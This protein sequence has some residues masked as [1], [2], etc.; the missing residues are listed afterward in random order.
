MNINELMFGAAAP[1]EKIKSINAMNESDLFSVP[2]STIKRIIEEVGEC[3]YQSTDK[4]LR[5]PRKRRAG[6]HWDSVLESIFLWKGN[7]YFD[8]YIQ[9]GDCDTDTNQS[10]SFAEVMKRGDY[11]G[12]IK[13]CDRYGSPKNYY[14]IYD[15]S[16]KADC[17]KSILLTY[18]DAKVEE[19]KKAEEAK[20]N[21]SK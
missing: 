21:E 19:A 18:V 3:R 5:I 12:T 15:N 7:V 14:Y 8:F 9:Y 1:E 6:N 16:D 17:I 20:A 4:F 13:D 2:S 10:A 11:R